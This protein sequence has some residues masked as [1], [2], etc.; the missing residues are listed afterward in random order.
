MKERVE[1][2]MVSEICVSD[3]NVATSSRLTCLTGSFEAF[4]DRR[5]ERGTRCETFDANERIQW[6]GIGERKE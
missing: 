4:E 3:L 1:I 5:S 6:R 2:L